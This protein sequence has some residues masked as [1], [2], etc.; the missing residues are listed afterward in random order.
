MVDN[1][2]D[3][4]FWEDFDSIC[5][6]LDEEPG[7]E[8]A[9]MPSGGSQQRFDAPRQGADP[10]AYSG[11]QPYH[12]GPGRPAPRPQNP[13][14]GSPAG[15][16]V[17]PMGGA[18]ALGRGAAPVRNGNPVMRQPAPQQVWNPEHGFEDPF[19]QEEKRKKK[20][21]KAAVIVL[22]IIIVLELA[23]IGF[24]GASWLLWMK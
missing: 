19:V 22:S 5:A 23:A 1:R 21:S 14:A 15:N 9:A 24:I 18:S 20:G 13:N 11:Q 8:N 3:D 16:R 6:L 7:G 17:P 4:N 10:R 12:Q 2:N